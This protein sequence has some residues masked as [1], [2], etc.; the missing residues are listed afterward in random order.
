[1]LSPA[2]AAGVRGRLILNQS[3]RF[4]LARR[5]QRDGLPLGELFSFI[6]GLYFRD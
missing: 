5:L 6:S 2:N 1:M 4:D 3:A